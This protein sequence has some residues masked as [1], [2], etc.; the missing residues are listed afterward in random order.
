MPVDNCI[1]HVPG[2]F[3]TFLVLVSLWKIQA[4]LDFHRSLVLGII[5][6]AFRGEPGKGV[7]VQSEML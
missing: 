4:L 7:N 3:Y 5:H 2:H 1:I 6:D